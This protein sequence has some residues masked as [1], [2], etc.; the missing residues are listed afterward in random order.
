MQKLVRAA[1]SAERI[2]EAMDA[3]GITQAELAASSGLSRSSISRYL[4]GQMEPKP[5]AIALLA[6]E[7]NVTEMWLWGYEVPQDR[8]VEQKKNDDRA[9]VIAR[10]RSDPDFNELVTQ[11]NNLPADQYDNIKQLV[12][13]LGKKK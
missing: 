11:L 10:L 5:K 2:R 6:R 8:P 1:G 12:S 9:K 7:L 13:A 4:S 3:K